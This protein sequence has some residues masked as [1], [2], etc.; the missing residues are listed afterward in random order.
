M[1]EPRVLEGGA[2]YILQI[3]NNQVCLIIY[4][5]INP[6]AAAATKNNN[7]RLH[8]CC[9]ITLRGALH[10]FGF[11]STQLASCGVVRVVDVVSRRG[12][13]NKTLGLCVLAGWLTATAGSS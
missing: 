8:W 13:S 10:L 12:G 7:S 3:T 2:L 4:D 6:L 9:Y 5:R 1:T 11:K